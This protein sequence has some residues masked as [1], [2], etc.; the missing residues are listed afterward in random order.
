MTTPNKYIVIEFPRWTKLGRS[1]GNIAELC[2]MN[3]DLVLTFLLI[4]NLYPGFK[5]LLA[6]LIKSIIQYSNVTNYNKSIDL[7]S[8]S[9]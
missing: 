3:I 9:C 6:W 2:C 5:I 4:P 1:K 8:Q 7:N